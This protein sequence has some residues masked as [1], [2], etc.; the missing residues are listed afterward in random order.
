[1]AATLEQ[2]RDERSQAEQA[3][4]DSE[5]RLQAILDN[6]AAVIVVKDLDGRYVLLNRRFQELFGLSADE[7][8][9]Q[10]A[11]DIFGDEVADPLRA[12]DRRVLAAAGPI[13]AEE[14]VPQDDGD[15]T[16]LS[17]KFPL[18]DPVSGDVYAIC[19][20]STDITERKRAERALEDA[21]EQAESA[22]QA[23]SRFLSRMSHELRTPLN[24]ILGFGQLLELDELD[25]AQRD[26]VEQIL[27]GGRHLLALINEV[28]EISR[29]EAGEM[30]MSMEPVDV[31]LALTEVVQLMGPLAAERGL[32]LDVVV[33]NGAP[34]FVRA[35]YQR[36]RQV[37][38]NLVSNATKYNIVG[39]RI[40]L[41]VEAADHDGVRIAVT[42][43]GTGIAADQ[44]PK[45]FNAFERLDADSRDVE[46]TGL[47]LALSK[48]L[49]E[50]ME[51]T[52]DVDSELGSG[53]TFSVV[54]RAAE[55]H[56]VT[57]TSEA[58]DQPRVQRSLDGSRRTVLCIEDN[59]S[60]IKLLERI[61]AGLPGVDLVAAGQGT[62]GLEL[63][64]QHRPDLILLDLNLPDMSGEAVL[65]QLFE[66][67]A[68]GE[69]PV[70]VLSADA[71]ER[72][73]ERLLALGARDYL[74]KPFDV[75]GLLEV[76]DT[77]L[78]GSIEGQR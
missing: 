50:A 67:P 75:K 20:I 42:D 55:H 21:T 25:P 34:E 23:K 56:Q 17:T 40:S 47:G 31:G 52:I 49:V 14:T 44:L 11:A 22:N 5:A 35:D 18:R 46:G 10:T 60:N 77:S 59:I 3:L 33:D 66:D 12:N 28:L 78:H 70:V 71:T 63:A 65:R 1:M 41:R 74:T 68:T 6:T 69:I 13:Q 64:R 39:G 24:A 72:Q 29:I 9:G 15:H 48:R 2:G 8:K 37:L 61:F 45:L 19:A 76:V 58:R 7:A 53:S 30:P 51:G 32:Q 43:T 54:L 4:R 16:Y 57:Q 38:L 26:N 27:K 73:I 36:L 62:L